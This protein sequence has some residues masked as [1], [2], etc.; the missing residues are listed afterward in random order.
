MMV[1][2]R[3]I[4]HFDWGLLLLTVI[5]CTMGLLSLHSAVSAGLDGADRS[6][7]LKQMVWYGAGFVTIGFVMVVDYRNIDRWSYIIYGGIIVML[8]G[9]LGFGKLAG[10]SRRWLVLGPV[11]IQPSE[12]AKLAVIIILA[13]YFSRRVKPQG[14]SLRELIYPSIL[15]LLPFLLIVNQPDL[16]TGLTVILIS[17][18]MT[19]FV[20]IERRTFIFLGLLGSIAM[21]MVWFFLKEYQ[22][23]RILTFLNPNR[24]PLGAGY[25]I[26]QSKIAIGSGMMLGKG[27]LKGTQNTLSFL[28]EQHTDFIFSVLAEEWGFIGASMTVLVY[29]TL[30]ILG[31]NIAYRCKDPFGTILSFGI[32]ALIFWQTFIN[33]GMVMGLLPVV[34]MPLPLIS[35]GGSSVITIMICIGMLMNVSMR[36]FSPD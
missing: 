14:F 2:R 15:I 18:S 13:R 30:V 31:L 11:S 3:L 28:P 16:G 29:L 26:I 21:P 36:Q 34:G 22:Q 4:Q 25:H 10:G 5:I 17:G 32:V 19:L 35:Y 7:F 1:D 27:F 33:L 20:K 8:I 6:F 23:Q 9:V 12:M 24:D